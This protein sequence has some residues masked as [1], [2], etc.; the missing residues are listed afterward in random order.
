MNR[1]YRHD[2]VEMAQ[3][4]VNR[5]V[6]EYNEWVQAVKEEIETEKAR[7]DE[8]LQA[9]RRVEAQIKDCDSHLETGNPNPGDRRAVTAYNSMV[10]KRNDLVK[11]QNRLAE[12]YTANQDAYNERVARFNR[13]T[14]ARGERLETAK[15]GAL[16]QMQDY[17]NWADSQKDLTFSADLN[18]FYAGL[19]REKART[20]GNS[21]LDAEIRRVQT[22]RLQLGE[23]AVKRH[24]SGK[25]GLIIVKTR[26]DQRETCFF[27]VDT[28]ASMV[29]LSPALVDVLGLSDR[30]GDEITLT[31]AGGIKTRGRK[32]VIPEISVLGKTAA[33]VN[34]VVLDAPVAGVDGLLGQTFLDRFAYRIDKSH[35]DKLILSR[36]RIKGP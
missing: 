31:L 33:N 36:R 15:Q 11:Q 2:P 22:M 35:P 25:S 12:A 6:S 9:L 4:S 14:A 23:H 10:L 17:E 30:L 21:G 34:A 29:T 8:Q 28:G 27:I 1:F 13:E 18:R 3:V 7:L 16:K 32:L 5:S 20:G 24:E 19:C 26:L